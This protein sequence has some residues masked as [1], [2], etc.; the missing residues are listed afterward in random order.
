ML[1]VWMKWT[2]VLLM[3]GDAVS[4]SFRLPFSLKSSCFT[5][6]SSSVLFAPKLS[7]YHRPFSTLL[8]PRKPVNM[9]D[10]KKRKATATA[11]DAE[12]SAKQPRE[13][14]PTKAAGWLHSL[15][16]QQRED[17]KDMKFSKKRQR[18]ISET[19]K[20]RQG[21]GGVLY[22]MLRDQRVQGKQ[23]TA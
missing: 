19:Q 6:H 21:S 5:S 17:K 12:P 13:D 4:G 22:W 15:I 10:K 18:F 2:P 3:R 16:R 14:K 8:Y 11:G 23:V 20:V 7:S 9:S 1:V